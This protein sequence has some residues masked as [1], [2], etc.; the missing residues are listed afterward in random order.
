MFI[1]NV[2]LPSLKVTEKF[3]EQLGKQALPGDIICLDGDLGAGKTTMARAIAKGLGVAQYCYVNSPSYAIMHEYC[4]KFPLYH[5]DFYRL[6]NSEDVLELGFDEYFYLS[7]LTVIEWAER[8]VE[9]LPE[10][11]LS[12]MIKHRGEE[13]REVVLQGTVHYQ[14]R[15]ESLLILCEARR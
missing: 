6:D 13:L 14:K 5:M 10:N 4:G 3:G 1:Y 7:G 11:R 12:I 15:I 8:A 2:R 9:I